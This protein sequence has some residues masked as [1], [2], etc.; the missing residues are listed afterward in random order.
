ME[1]YSFDAKYISKWPVLGWTE[2]GN[3][4]KYNSDKTEMSF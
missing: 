1:I 4:F 3:C 2:K